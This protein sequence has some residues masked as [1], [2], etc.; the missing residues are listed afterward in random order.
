VA[1][2]PV[3]WFYKKSPPTAAT[4][5]LEKPLLVSDESKFV[6]R[7]L[8]VSSPQ[9][10]RTQTVYE[11]VNY[12]SNRGPNVFRVRFEEL[13]NDIFSNFELAV[14]ADHGQTWI[15]TEKWK[16][17]KPRSDGQERRLFIY[18]SF[19]DPR[20]GR[21][22]F[23]GNE[24]VLRNDHP[25]D[26]QTNNYPIYRASNDGGRTWLF[27]ERVIQTGKGFTKERPFEGVRIGSNSLTVS[28]ALTHGSDGA[29]VVPVQVS[30]AGPDGKLYR[31]PGAY[32]Y[33]DA[34]VLIGKWRDDGRLDWQLSQRLNLPPDKSLR[35]IFEPT[36]AEFPDGRMLMVCRSN[37]G[38]KWFSVSSDGGL[39][40]AKPDVWRYSDGTLFYSPSS[41]SRLIRH[42]GGEYCWIGNISP[43]HPRGNAPR[44]PLVIGRV[45][46]KSLCLIRE[47]VTTID[48]RGPDDVAGLQL[49]NFCVHEDRR[50]H[51]FHVRVTRWDERASGRGPV[52]G[53]MHAFQVE[54]S[55]SHSRVEP[56]TTGNIP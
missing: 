8:G 13:K 22:L 29:V 40:W 23:L 51:H 34:A 17:V 1:W 7:K 10:D 26:G 52:D 42:S 20:N 21:L 15:D 3:E 18:G 32:T 55:K 12:A 56:K 11:F 19:F 47:S 6:V 48:T 33:L 30:H 37:S 53:S 44:Y 24:G 31:P 16:S 45:D 36:V 39:T 41:I 2:F 9:K 43:D 25:L 27:E 54:L 46:P 50:T 49:S 14:S 4:E 28:N 38:R 35:G 5:S